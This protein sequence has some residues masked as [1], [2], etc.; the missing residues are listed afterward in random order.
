[1]FWAILVAVLMLIG[2]IGLFIQIRREQ[3]ETRKHYDRS[4]KGLRNRDRKNRSNRS[5]L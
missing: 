5:S 3:L 4:F 1:M 2:V